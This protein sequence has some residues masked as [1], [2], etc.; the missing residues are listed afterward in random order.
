CQPPHVRARSC[1]PRSTLVLSVLTEN[2]ICAV[3]KLQPAIVSGDRHPDIRAVACERVDSVARGR[4]VK[5]VV[6][7]VIASIR[8]LV[9]PDLILSGILMGIVCRIARRY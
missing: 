3:R 6:E 2:L 8:A 7:D 9:D 5:T 4:V 1:C